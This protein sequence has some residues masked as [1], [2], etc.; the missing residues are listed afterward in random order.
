MKKKRKII[1]ILFLIFTS[2]S[3]FSQSIGINFYANKVKEKNALHIDSVACVYK[4]TNTDSIFYFRLRKKELGYEEQFNGYNV[5]CKEFNYVKISRNNINHWLYVGNLKNDFYKIDFIIDTL[6]LLNNTPNDTSIIK[7]NFY[8][9]YG[10]KYDGKK[11]QIQNIDS[12]HHYANAYLKESQKDSTNSMF[13]NERSSNESFA[14]WYIPHELK[15]GGIINKKYN[16]QFYVAYYPIGF[17]TSQPS[18]EE[19]YI[20]AGVSYT[21]MFNSN[22]IS[23]FPYYGNIYWV[24]IHKG[25]KVEPMYNIGSGKIEYANLEVQFG[26]MLSLSLSLGIPTDS[27]IN[28]LYGGFKIGYSL[29][30]P[31]FQKEPRHEKQNTEK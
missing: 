4:R 24:G 31:I 10:E 1:S 2:L 20:A 21:R 30:Y 5:Y 23:V 7:M 27:N 3:C 13:K 22:Y 9:L 12:Y 28:S 16:S 14:S 15:Y 19:N 6:S 29:P 8:Y 11:Y 25:V 26:L 17:I 18:E